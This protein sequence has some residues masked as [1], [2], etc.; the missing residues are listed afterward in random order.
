MAVPRHVADQLAL[1]LGYQQAGR[2]IQQLR[3]QRPRES[4]RARWRRCGKGTNEL[5]QRAPVRAA[6]SCV[7]G[8]AFARTV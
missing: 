1:V 4:F 8:S 2:A 5:E 7:A 3:V 6:S